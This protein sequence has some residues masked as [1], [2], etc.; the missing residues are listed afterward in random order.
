MTLIFEKTGKSETP[1]VSNGQFFRLKSQTPKYSTKTT[2]Y[3]QFSP[4]FLQTWLIPIHALRECCIALA[5][6]SSP[7]GA[8]KFFSIFAAKR[9]IFWPFRDFQMIFEWF[10]YGALILG[11][12]L[13]RGSWAQ[14]WIRHSSMYA[15]S[16]RFSLFWLPVGQCVK[17][18]FLSLP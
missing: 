8:R 10:F 3:V 16:R 17:T 2:E 12:F 11:L 1:D 7:N 15:D 13:T 5:P 18:A 14:T 6:P 4:F 9:Q